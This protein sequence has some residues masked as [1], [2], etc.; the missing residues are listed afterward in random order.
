MQ[1]NFFLLLFLVIIFPLKISAARQY[2]YILR[3]INQAQA[4]MVL[5]G[6]GDALGR[7]TEFK[8]TFKNIF[9]S[10]PHGILN[11]DSF[12][13][14]DW[15]GIPESIIT[16]P[17]KPY[18]KKIA[19]YTD[20]TAMAILVADAFVN[21]QKQVVPV[22]TKS[23]FQRIGDFFWRMWYTPSKPEKQSDI[24]KEIPLN[25]VMS[26]IANNFIND[27]NNFN[28]WAAGFRAPGISAMTA[29]NYAKTLDQSSP[30]WW[31]QSEFT[32]NF[33]GCGSVMRAHPC[34]IRFFNDAAKAEEYAVAQSKITHSH[35]WALAACAA[36][37]VGVAHSLD[38]KSIQE[39]ELI[40]YMK[41]AAD[42]YDN[43]SAINTT[44][45]KPNSRS[46][47]QK[48]EFAYQ[49]ALKMRELLQKNTVTTAEALIKELKNYSNEIAILHAQMCTEFPGWT[50]DDAIA[51]TVYCS[52]S[53]VTVSDDPRLPI[54]LGVHTT[55]DSDSI[56]SMTGA[57][58]GAHSG[59][60]PDPE[61]RP[62]GF[63]GGYQM[64]F[65]SMPPA[66]LQRIEGAD[67]LIDIGQAL[68]QLDPFIREHTYDYE[69]TAI[70]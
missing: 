55:G 6:Y 21:P 30:T 66:E 61:K 31:D 38:P 67:T 62:A 5:A 28:G 52:F 34:G 69:Y 7:V 3:I 11:F 19:P 54:L 70:D 4:S 13:A 1:K 68:I 20:D 57:L 27:A 58:I 60:G 24:S 17:H 49:N 25:D 14:T 32:K 16:N 59:F 18:D 39:T 51:A 50:A 8:K 15:N 22:V 43:G 40:K 44:T 41:E 45:G 46:T 29:V 65:G 26:T 12:T 37:A 56:A 35:P 23:I 36:M 63:V 33:G 64:T 42:R 9:T 53:F 48:I 47:G 10:Y 2:D